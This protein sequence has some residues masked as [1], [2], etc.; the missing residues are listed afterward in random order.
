MRDDSAFGTFRF[1]NPGMDSTLKRL[2][3]I[4]LCLLPFQNIRLPFF[5]IDVFAQTPAYIRYL[6]EIVFIVTFL[7][8]LTFIVLR[9]TSYV[10]VKFPFNIPVVIFLFVALLSLAINQVALLQGCFGIY[11]MIKNILVVYAFAYLGFTRDDLMRVVGLLTKVALLMGVVAILAEFAAMMWGVGIGFFVNPEKRFG[12]YRVVSLAGAG[13]W[14]Y[15]G[16]YMTLLFYLSLVSMK[17]TLFKKGVLFTS[18]ATVVLTFSRQSWVGLGIMACALNRRMIP[19]GL[20]FLV[21]VIWMFQ[22]YEFSPTSNFRAFAFTESLDILRQNPLFGVGPGMFGG[23]GAGIFGTPIYNFWPSNFAD[24]ALRLQ[25]IDM[26][27]PSVWGELGLV[28]FTAYA[29]IWMSIFFYL[30]RIVKYFNGKD[31]RIMRDI[32]NVLRYFILAIGVMGFGGGLNAAF[33]SFTYFALVGMYISAY[34]C[35]QKDSG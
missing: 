29:S 9:P 14:N 22:G 30:G 6:D 13:S 21:T 33:V 4:F 19:F 23:L 35:M 31:D 2:L 7:T 28:G 11:D 20:F 8:L 5:E 16:I 27:W 1:S 12:L 34:L 24:F 17:P 32:G 3:I 15:L 10:M 25:G 18:L 26:F